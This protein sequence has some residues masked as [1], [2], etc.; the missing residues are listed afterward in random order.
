MDN[1][2]HDMKAPLFLSISNISIN[3]N[4]MFYQSIFLIGSN[5]YFSKKRKKKDVMEIKILE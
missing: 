5:G 3:K 2:K 1:P 4:M